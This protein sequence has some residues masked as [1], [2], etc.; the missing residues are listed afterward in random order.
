MGWGSNFNRICTYGVFR[1]KENEERFL[2]INAHFD[3]ESELA[4]VNSAQLILNWIE[5][6]NKEDLPMIL[7]RF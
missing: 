2:V 3:H 7:I 6:N 5:E 1:H 4:R